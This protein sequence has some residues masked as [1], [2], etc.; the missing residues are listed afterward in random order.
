MA[1]LLYRLAHAARR[2]RG[3]VLGIWLLVLA[4]AG[5]GALGFAGQTTNQFSIPGTESQRALDHLKDKLPQAAGASGRIVFAAPQGKTLAQEQQT[6]DGVIAQIGKTEQV[7]GAF[8]PFVTQAVSQ[9][10]RIGLAQVQ[11]SVS[12]PEVK[13]STKDAIKTAVQA[14]ANS[15]M[16]VAYSQEIAGE[17]VAIGV[18]EGI[19]VVIA[20]IVLVLTFGS[21]VA[22]GLPLL[23]AIVG[24][25]IGIGG[26]YALTSVIDMSSTAPVLALMLG[27]AVG[28]DYA[29]FIVHRHRKQVLGGMEVNESIARA[30]GTAGSAVFFAGLTV[31]IAL[32][33]LTVVGIPF[34]SVMGLAAAATVAIA[35]LVAL[36][37]VPAILGFVGEKIVSEKARA[38]ATAPGQKP[39]FGYRW[40][41][42]VAKRPITALVLIVVSLGAI[43]IPAFSLEMGLPDD[44]TAPQGS[45]Q[46]RANALV[47]EA[48]GPGFSGPLVVVADL[49]S[50][51][52]PQQALG[53]LVGKLSSVQDVTRVVPAGVSPDG[54]TAVLQVIPGSGPSTEATKDLVSRLRELTGEV[55]SQTGSTIGVTG[56]TALNIDVSQK[57]SDA[58]P[59]YL[60][61]IVGL[62]LILLAIMFRS[63]LVPIKAT[64]GFL[65]TVA[66]SIGAVVAI[67]QWG[68]LGDLF[69]ITHGSPII[70]FLPILMTGILFGLAMDYEV[71]LVSGMREAFVRGDTPKEAVIDG[72]G[73]SAR[74][75]TAAAL[76][77]TAVFF[78]FV[79]SHDTVIKSMGFALAFGVM[80]DA[81]VIR[82]TLVPALMTLFGK[83]AWWF[84]RLL[85]RITPNVDV[86]GETLAR[87]IGRQEQHEKVPQPV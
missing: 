85:D 54:T 67:F 56:Q 60:I 43:A 86:E 77:M 19:G 66:A 31:I 39:A 16:E 38:K 22:A 37:L 80:I 46:Q 73:H 47:T 57:L 12:P 41:R 21:L 11:F 8:S 4:V 30:I 5:I 53:A 34:L 40:G 25:G 26:L 9:D 35:V 62:S 81:F 44:S 29:L 20:A 48:F 84:P 82:M 17:M 78:G 58:L 27:L 50:G 68:W 75:V 64:A 45:P 59:T 36:T 10:G 49:P 28:I 76:I 70:S 52:N 13:E 24:V 14:A 63:I 55:K 74:V 6:I 65:L 23:T 83:A 69:G 1:K 7:A 32:V 33:G 79:F 15:G 71:F 2:R 42:A 87:H 51:V 3:L 61:V 72:L 18:T